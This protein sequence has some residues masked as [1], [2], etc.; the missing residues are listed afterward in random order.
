[1]CAPGIPREWQVL[2]G[3]VVGGRGTAPVRLVTVVVGAAGEGG[4]FGEIFLALFLPTTVH[5][6]VSILWSFAGAWSFA[7]V[8]VVVS[9]A[10]LLSMVL[11]CC[12]QSR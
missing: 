1:M 10:L 7:I 8:V 5:P 2:V 6:S 4:G 3:A 9:S 12:C 11:C